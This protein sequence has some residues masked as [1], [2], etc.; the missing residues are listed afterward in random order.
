MQHPSPHPP[1]IIENAKL[2]D[3]QGLLKCKYVFE[4]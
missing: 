4:M 2:S 3:T 1:S